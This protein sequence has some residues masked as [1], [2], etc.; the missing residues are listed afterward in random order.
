M[1]AVCSR[2]EV[3]NGVWVGESEDDGWMS[4]S[5]E[6]AAISQQQPGTGMQLL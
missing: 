4:D 2:W 3:V 1:I 6:V 5:S